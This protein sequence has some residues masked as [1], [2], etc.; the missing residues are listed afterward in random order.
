MLRKPLTETGFDIRLPLESLVVD[1]AGERTA[2]GGEFAQPVPP[3][4]RDATRRNMLGEKLLDFRAAGG[5]PPDGRGNLGR[6]R[7]LPG[8][9]ARI[10]QG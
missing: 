1:D 3:K 8:A 5:D 2:A 7:P 9:R 4:D 10:A 6:T